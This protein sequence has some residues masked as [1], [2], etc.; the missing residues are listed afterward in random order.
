MK[1]NK[2]KGGNQAKISP[3]RYMRERV[4]N[5]PIGVC[6]INPNWEKEGLAH[7]IVT[8]NRA[9]GQI[10]YASFLI[11]TFCL[12]VKDAEYAIDFTAEELKDALE[13]FRATHDLVETDYE[14]VHNLIYGA[15]EFAEEGGIEPVK[16]FVPASYIL[17]EDTDDIPLIEF[18]YGKEG[19]HFLIIGEDGKERRH[20]KTLFDHL[21][22][23]FVY[24][25][26][27]NTYDE[28]EESEG[29]RELY[30]EKERHL[31]EEYSYAYPEYPKELKVKNQF[32]A[33]DLLSEDNYEELP[34]EVIRR[35][36]SLPE[37][38]AAED[39]SNIMLYTIGKTYKAIE[40]DTIGEPEEGSLLHSVILLTQLQS[41]NGLAGLL[42]TIRQTDRFIDFHFGD[43]APELIPMAISASAGDNLAPVESYLYE[44]GLDSLNR[45]LAAEALAITANLN[46]EKRQEVIDIF[47]RLIISMKERLPER[48]GCD[49]EFAGFVVSYLIDM[50]ARELIPE[51]KEL[52]A[53]E[54]V[55]KTI[56]GDCD[57]AVEQI[58]HNLYPRN[59]ELPTIQEQYE[60]VKSFG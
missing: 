33:D 35:I 25:D 51:V 39:I 2:K 10:V 52:F 44:P 49:A 26:L 3:E 32:I 59:Y 34:K 30:Q 58:E 28:E 27:A 22:D 23:Q 9:G 41:E 15:I 60:Y 31:S 8:R 42:E 18:E 55:D 21:G 1:K 29:I 43:L 36:L 6:Y 19:K 5:L 46:P 47:R 38:E 17:E 53:T 37:D 4:R 11:D 12:G 14:K 50:E 24:V 48:N 54:C 56:A 40:D 16:E 20:M 57:E 13:H 7:I 45:S